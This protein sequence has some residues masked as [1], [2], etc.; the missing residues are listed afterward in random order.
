M[1]ILVYVKTMKKLIIELKFLIIIVT[2]EIE[3]LLS[4]M[5]LYSVESKN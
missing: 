2:N 5:I 3:T 4:R 1:N